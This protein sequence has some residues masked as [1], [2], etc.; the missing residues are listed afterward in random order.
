MGVLLSGNFTVDDSKLVGLRKQRFRDNVCPPYRRA[1]GA[2]PLSSKAICRL[3]S[4]STAI[5]QK[6]APLRRR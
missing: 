4:N 2:D 3:W 1:V 5:D 6:P